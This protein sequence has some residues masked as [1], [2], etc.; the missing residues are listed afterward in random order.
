M[1]ASLHVPML[2]KRHK[3]LRTH[4]EDQSSTPSRRVKFRFSLV[5]DDDLRAVLLVSASSHLSHGENVGGGVNEQSRVSRLHAGPHLKPGCRKKFG[6]ASC[7][8][9]LREGGPACRSYDYSS[10]TQSPSSPPTPARCY[11]AL[12]PTPTRLRLK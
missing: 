6:E 10:R 12:N 9:P 3:T 4:H 2:N 1:T 5:H 7:D 8:P 11:R